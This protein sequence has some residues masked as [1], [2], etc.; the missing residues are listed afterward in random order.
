MSPLDE[1]LAAVDRNG[2]TGQEPGWPPLSDDGPAG[3]T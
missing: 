2:N 1:V 3:T